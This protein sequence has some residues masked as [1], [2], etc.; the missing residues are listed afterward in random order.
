MSWCRPSSKDLALSALFQHVFS[1][2]VRRLQ[3]VKDPF[4]LLQQFAVF[5][6]TW[7]LSPLRNHSSPQPLTGGGVLVRENRKASSP[8]LTCSQFSCGAI[9]LSSCELLAPMG[10]EWLPGMAGIPSTPSLSP[11][12]SLDFLLVSRSVGFMNVHIPKS[13]TFCFSLGER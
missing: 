13:E 2:F 7:R 11:W 9:I 5:L 8:L 12:A 3:T 1:V 10:P 4:L 6:K